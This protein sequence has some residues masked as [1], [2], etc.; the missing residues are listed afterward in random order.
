MRSGSSNLE[1]A[2]GNR[3]SWREQVTLVVIF[4]ALALVARMP[5]LLQGVHIS[6]E[7]YLLIHTLLEFAA[8]LAAFLVFAT[9]WHMPAKDTSAFLLLIAAALFACGW[10]DFAHAVSLREMPGLIT[11]ASV[12][13]GIAFGLAARLPVELTLLGVSLYPQLRLLSE[14][15]RYGILAGYTFVGR[16]TDSNRD[17]TFS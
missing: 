6:L 16:K 2:T 4:A 12:E 1:R 17:L 13:K 11:A 15:G 7:H 3:N 9:V 10:L 5:A 8:V 14:R